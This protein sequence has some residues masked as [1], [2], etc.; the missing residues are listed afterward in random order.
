MLDTLLAV[1]LD[2]DPLVRQ[3]ERSL[4]ELED[5]HGG[6]HPIALGLDYLRAHKGAA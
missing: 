2:G 4:R 5:H 6:K 3:L 1:G